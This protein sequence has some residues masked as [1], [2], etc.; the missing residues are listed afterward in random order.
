MLAK[1]AL[2]KTWRLFQRLQK[3]AK[4][5]T[6]GVASSASRPRRYVARS[7]GQLQSEA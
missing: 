1:Y 2:S 4:L 3:R 7:D 6:T 5:E